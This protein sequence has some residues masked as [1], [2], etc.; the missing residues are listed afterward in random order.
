RSETEK[1][2]LIF[3]ELGHA[4]LQRGHTNGTLPN[5]SQKSL[6]CASETCNNYRVYNSNQNEQRSYYLDELVSIPNTVPDWAAQKTFS[7]T[8]AED[9][10]DNGIEGWTTTIGED[11]NTEKPYDFYIDDK[12]VF[13]PP[14]ALGITATSDSSMSTFGHWQKTY[15]LSD[16]ENCSNLLIRT[17]IV[18]E[19][20]GSGTVG[21]AVELL[22]RNTAGE[23][24]FFAR[25]SNAMRNTGTN[26]VNTESFMAEVI[27]L[28]P[29]TGAIRVLLYMNGVTEGTVASFDNLE[30]ELYE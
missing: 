8:L 28:P 24:E 27:C 18:T 23:F 3:H 2:N 14:S 16:F 13:S 17:A 11:L 22:E 20:F 9:S 26:S 1:E 6:M 10:F 7:R 29:E 21:I 30:I 12:K 15:T 4:L 25:Y 19:A 5:G